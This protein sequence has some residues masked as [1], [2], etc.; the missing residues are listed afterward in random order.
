MDANAGILAELSGLSSGKH[1]LRITL[2]DGNGQLDFNR[3][4]FDAGVRRYVT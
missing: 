3:V 1:I 4:V 2:E